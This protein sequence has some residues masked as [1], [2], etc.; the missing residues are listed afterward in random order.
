MM[1]M[2][3]APNSLVRQK[4]GVQAEEEDEAGDQRKRGQTGTP[5]PVAVFLSAVFLRRFFTIFN[6]LLFRSRL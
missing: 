1:M 4:E 6:Q 5:T 2:M 3:I